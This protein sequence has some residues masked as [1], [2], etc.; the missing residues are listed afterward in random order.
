MLQIIENPIVVIASGGFDPLHIGHLEY[1][2]SAK[3][4]GHSL[5]VGV[6]SDNWLKRKKGYRFQDFDDRVAIVRALQWV[7]YA[8]GFDDSDNS[9]C[10]M[11]RLVIEQRKDASKIIFANGGDRTKKNI[12]EMIPEFK[13]KVEFVFNVGG[14]DKLNSSSK[15]V[16]RLVHHHG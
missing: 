2:K 4:L 3:E 12:P 9:A 15:I 7:D 8:T 16:Q 14:E 13:D 11:I 5:Y 10:D 6:N 1:L